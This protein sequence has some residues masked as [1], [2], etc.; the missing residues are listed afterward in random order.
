VLEPNSYENLGVL[1]RT[2]NEFEHHWNEMAQ[3]FEWN[4]TRDDLANP[5]ARLAAYEPQL[6]LAVRQGL[7]IDRAKACRTAPSSRGVCTAGGGRGEALRHSA[8]GVPP[9]ASQRRSP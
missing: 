9:V 1:A 4:F 7:L 6:R 5:I 3:P 8:R 2:L